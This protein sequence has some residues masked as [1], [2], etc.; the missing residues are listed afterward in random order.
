SS[1]GGALE[2]VPAYD[3]LATVA[4]GAGDHPT[5]PFGEQD[6]AYQALAGFHQLTRAAR[7][8]GACGP[9]EFPEP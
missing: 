5:F 2:V 3:K 9:A 6:P 7:D 8:A 4:G 1:D